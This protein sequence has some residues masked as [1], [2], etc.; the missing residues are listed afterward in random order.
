MSG[1]P[2][3]G[4]SQGILWLAWEIK[5]GLGKSGNLKIIGLAGSLQKI[6]FFCSRGEHT[7]CLFC[8]KGESTLS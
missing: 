4:K 6:Y 3:S 2:W 1:L 7:F 5:K 8:S